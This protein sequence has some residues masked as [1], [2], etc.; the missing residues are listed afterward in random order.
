[1]LSKLTLFDRLIFRHLFKLLVAFDLLP[2]NLSNNDLKTVDLILSE[3]EFV[4]IKIPVIL[5]GLD[6]TTNLLRLSLNGG[7]LLLFN[8]YILLELI[9]LINDRVQLRLDA[10]FLTTQLLSH[11]AHLLLVTLKG[12]LSLKLLVGQLSQLFLLLRK[13]ALVL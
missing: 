9:E 13:N 6:L 2:F 8:L 12:L 11:L 3:F 4:L 7:H 5:Y 10:L 1:M